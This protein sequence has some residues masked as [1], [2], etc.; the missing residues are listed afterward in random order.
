MKI[1]DI[2]MP[3]SYDMPVYKAREAK[4]TPYK[5]TKQFFQMLQYM[6]QG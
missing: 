2:S 6:S 1:I 4:K 3:V 5:R